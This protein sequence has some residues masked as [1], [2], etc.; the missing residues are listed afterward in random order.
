LKLDN[1]A[2]KAPLVCEL[3]REAGFEAREDDRTH[4]GKEL[5]CELPME[6]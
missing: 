5:W 4:D 2:V 1:W 3:R 6:D